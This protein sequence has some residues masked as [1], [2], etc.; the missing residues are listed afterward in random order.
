MRAFYRELCP[1]SACG[2]IA[3][4]LQINSL[5]RCF[6]AHAIVNEGLMQ[7]RGGNHQ[8]LLLQD[9]SGEAVRASP[10]N[11]KSLACCRVA[12]SILRTSR[13]NAGRVG[14]PDRHCS[15]MSVFQRALLECLRNFPGSAAISAIWFACF[16][17]IPF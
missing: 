16:G 7:R 15:K 4:Q 13:Q 9:A 17:F 3:A 2:Q 1:Y 10:P 14:H 6:I 5:C 8:V 11:P 12:K